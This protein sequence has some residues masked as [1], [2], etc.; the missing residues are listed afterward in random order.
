MGDIDA[1]RA[2]PADLRKLTYAQATVVLLSFGFGSDALTRMTRRRLIDYVR[3][4]AVDLLYSLDGTVSD[5]I[6]Q[7]PRTK[8]ARD[9][10]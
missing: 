2:F 7:D 6:A 9:R 5:P 3:A 1:M 8:W 10:R 4:H